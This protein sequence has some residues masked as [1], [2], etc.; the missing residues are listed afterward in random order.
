MLGT[1]IQFHYGKNRLLFGMHSSMIVTIR[2]STL[3]V[4]QLIL[5]K[6]QIT[7]LDLA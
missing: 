3:A 2:R 4:Q 7:R 5:Q 1:E 6:S